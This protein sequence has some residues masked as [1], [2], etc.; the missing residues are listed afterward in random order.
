MQYIKANLIQ[1]IFMSIALG[2]L[3][4]GFLMNEALMMA[5][6]SILAM[7]VWFIDSIVNTNKIKDLDERLKNEEEWYEGD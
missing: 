6:S 3:C 5:I 7:L 4:C 1:I 2:L